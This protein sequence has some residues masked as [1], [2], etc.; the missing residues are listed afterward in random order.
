M[1]TCQHLKKSLWFASVMLI[2]LFS[3]VGCSDSAGTKEIALAQIQP[4]VVSTR[5][6][7]ER[8]LQSAVEI[9]FKE[10][11]IGKLAYQRASAQ[12]LKDLAKWYED[13]NRASKSSLA[14]LA[15]MES[16]KVPSA[17]TPTAHEVYNQ[18]NLSTIE[19]FDAAY[20]TMA[21][22]Y[23]NDAISLFESALRTNLDPDIKTW[24]TA[25]LSEM[26]AEHSKFAAFGTATDHTV[27]ETAP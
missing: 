3:I 13:T 24:A 22:Q 12:E 14:S 17:P 4:A 19:E 7:D 26:R 10:I 1:L 21:N 18:L 6:S 8:F 16:I 5:E 15:I 2:S 20:L 9:Y 27:A 11:L 23:Y 25:K